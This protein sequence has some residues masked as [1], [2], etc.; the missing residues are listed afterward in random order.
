MART[1]PLGKIKN[2]A[3]DSI[4]D[5]RRTA[6]TV[7]GQARGTVALGRFVVGQV[8]TRVAGIWQH[9]AAGKPAPTVAPPAP[10]RSPEQAPA[11]PEVRTT[12]PPGDAPEST[13]PEVTPADIAKNIAPKPAAKKTTRPPAKKA[14]T[15]KSAPG[16]KLP[17]RK[18]TPTE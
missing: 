1:N 14:P 13:E 5:P 18:K 2:V 4:K 3:I 17:P 11:A 7:A 10:R 12:T 8:G 15:K 9:G 6:G 16:A